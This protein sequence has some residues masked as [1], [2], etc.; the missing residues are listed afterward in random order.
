MAGIVDPAALGPAL[1]RELGVACYNSLD[2]LLAATEADALVVAT[3]NRTHE[4]VG[5]AA[6]ARGLH[7][8]VEKPI[9]HDLA[10]ARRLVAAAA[11]AGVHL[12]VGHHR[13]YNPVVERTRELLNQGAIGRLVAVSAHWMLRKP[14]AYFADDW[15]RNPGGGPVLI[16]L[17][18]DIDLL[19]H[20]CGEIVEVSA[21]TSSAMRGFSVEDTAAILLRFETGALATVLVSDAA[22]S[23]WN[24]ESAS[25]DNPTV[26]AGQQNCY[27]FFGSE[28]ALE[29]PNL[30]LWR[31]DG[32]PPG[33]WTMP[34]T[35]STLET[36]GAAP[37]T[38]ALRGQL[39]HFAQ[40]IR[41]AE[42]ARVTGADATRTLAATL[43]VQSAHARK[44]R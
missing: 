8:L 29:F 32:A 16:N 14:D 10:S 27:R 2:A 21:Q 4:A 31:H 19:R 30:K 26:P 17:I 41:G 5:T 9:A 33:D 22:P 36:P 35:A 13:R 23:P 20:L 44:A 34:L 6:A 11:Q 1:A 39:R 25:A 42:A 12:L 7:L 37:Q 3:P 38:D 18:H 24:W 28:A 15:R 40:V 43:A